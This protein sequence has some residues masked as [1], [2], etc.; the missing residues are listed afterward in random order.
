MKKWLFF[1][2]FGVFFSCE[3][4]PQRPIGVSDL[5]TGEL[6]FA[7]TYLPCDVSIDINCEAMPIF[8]AT[9]R[10]W[11]LENGG[12]E[13]RFVSEKKTNAD[14]RLTFD[15]VPLGIYEAVV[16]TNYGDQRHSVESIAGMPTEIQV[17][18]S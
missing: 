1:L 7:V 10:L 17:E 4:T 8:D 15:F 2:F 18:F 6:V 16:S 9:V 5:V 11:K 13:R 14:G 3:K 12:N